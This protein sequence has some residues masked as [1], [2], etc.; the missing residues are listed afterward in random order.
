M[1]QGNAAGMANTLLRKRLEPMEEGWVEQR[2][3]K[4]AE[5]AQVPSEWDIQPK[6]IEPKD[7]KDEIGSGDEETDAAERMRTKRVQGS[8]S[9]D[10]L[11]EMWKYAHQ[12]VFDQQY[13]KT[14]YPEE[15]G[16]GDGEGDAGDEGSVYDDES[17]E[18]KD[19]EDEDDDDDD[20]ED[21]MDTSNTPDALK[22]ESAAT[23]ILP[24]P[25]VAAQKPAR[26]KLA[27]HKPIPGLPVLSLGFVH[28]FMALG[29][30]TGL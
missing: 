25:G 12:E 7:D 3:Q 2:L 6:K 29:D 8:L 10:D 1:L 16:G 9:E 28:K 22:D 19:D 23:R 14:R 4:A 17:P 24:P 5:F 30:A 11:M 15:Y 27:V 20:F 21:V 26:A 18:S 13:L